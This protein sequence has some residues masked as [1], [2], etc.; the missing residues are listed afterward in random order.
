MLSRKELNP[1]LNLS[2]LSP[3][4]V[5]IHKNCCSYLK[6]NIQLKVRKA[7]LRN[8]PEERTSYTEWRKPEITHVL[9]STYGAWKVRRLYREPA[10]TGRNVEFSD[11]P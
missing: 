8:I 1:Q 5:C 11:V 6:K 4:L 3:L 10:E 9:Y 2:G 7:A